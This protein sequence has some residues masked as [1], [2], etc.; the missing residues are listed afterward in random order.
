MK[1]IL[2]LVNWG[3]SFFALCID[4][5]RSPIWAVWLTLAWFAFSTFLVVLGDRKGLFDRIKNK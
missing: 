5:E 2:I 1:A 4:T 3:F